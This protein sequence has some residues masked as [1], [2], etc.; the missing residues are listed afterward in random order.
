MIGKI[1]GILQ[2]IRGNQAYIETTSGVTYLAYILPSL[3]HNIGSQ[4]QVYTHL[5]VKEDALVLYAFETQDEYRLYLKL[6][7][8][9]GIGAKLAFNIC[10]FAK[11]EN[12]IGAVTGQDIEFFKKIPGVGKKTAQRILLELSGIVGTEFDLSSLA[13]SQ[14]DLTVLDA[15]E[16]LGF[17]KKDSQP[18]LSSLP[19]DLTIEEKI[20]QVIQYMTKKG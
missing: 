3:A 8:I 1:T 10:S 6:I 13:I 20:Q 19:K 17:S 15:L 7:A 11:P 16:S 12:I 14:D 9:D 18:A 2:E 4:V 5:D